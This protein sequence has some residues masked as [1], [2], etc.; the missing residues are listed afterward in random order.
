MPPPKKKRIKTRVFKHIAILSLLTKAVP[1]KDV[2]KNKHLDTKSE[3]I[4]KYENIKP[5]G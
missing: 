1:K 3:N 2:S 5:G 4:T